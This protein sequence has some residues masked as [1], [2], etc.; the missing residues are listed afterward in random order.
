MRVA[1]KL[2][3]G[4]GVLIALLAGL[5]LYQTL[6][7]FQASRRNQELL[8]SSKLTLSATKQLQ[9]LDEY[10][11]NVRKYLVTREPGYAAKATEALRA[12]SQTLADLRALP[13]SE[14]ERAELSRLVDLWAGYGGTGGGAVGASSGT[15]DDATSL[16]SP[17]DA[18]PELRQQTRIVN[19][20]GQAAMV[21]ELEQSAAAA[22][23]TL[24]IA[25]I[26]L[27]A[28][29]IS[30]AVI[31]ARIVRSIS[32]SLRYLKT[33]TQAVSRG[34]F[35]YRLTSVDDD[36]FS[37]LGTDFNGMIA[38]L[39]ELDQVKKDFLSHV[40]HELKTPLAS[41]QE[42]NRL[43]LEELPGGLND[44][45]RHLVNL[46]LKSASRL[47]D[48]ITKMLKQSQIEAG[49]I[50]YEFVWQ[51]IRELVATVHAELAAGGLAAGRIDPA[52]SPEPLVVAC[53]GHHII[54]VVHNLVENALKYSP[55]GTTVRVEA[56]YMERAPPFVPPHL[57][58]RLR[59]PRA[60]TGYAVVSVADQGPGIAIEE[61]EKIFSRFY[62]G[63]YGRT[64]EG[65]GV[66][67]GL[68]LSRRIVEA[69]GGI[70][71]VRDNAPTG[72]VF[73]FVLPDA[74]PSVP[75]AGLFAATGGATGPT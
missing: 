33:G 32:E 41:I 75:H 22:R 45:Q 62:Q 69:H 38:R 71:S 46:N 42:V 35:D 63:R 3:T 43:L 21:A 15:A 51:D 23:R 25:L 67:L 34:D 60:G 27:A 56:S 18:V 24:L 39:G 19:E 36:E 58:G 74:V 1:T 52:L 8:T 48:M 31:A 4:Y 10:N 26:A 44:K 11:E 13:L 65:G 61:Q 16:E 7:I 49:R 72:T 66:G 12:F 20:A 28:A 73:S 55:Q 5:L 2:A 29:L 30:S 9:H 14:T 6:V 40:S 53:D 50:E 70:L 37:E 57:R 47:S 17:A 54:Q 68:A 59:R 64:S